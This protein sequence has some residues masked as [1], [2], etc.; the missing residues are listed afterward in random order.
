MQTGPLGLW[1]MEQHGA[2]LYWKG[3]EEQMIAL[4]KAI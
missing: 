4:Q 2:A 1:K 3:I